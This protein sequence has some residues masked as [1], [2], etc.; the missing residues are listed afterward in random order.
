MNNRIKQNSC[1]AWLLAARPKTLSAASIPVVVASALAW[2]DGCFRM[3]PA[4]TCLLFAWLMQIAA[5]M[6]NDLFDFLKGS[7][8]S[9]RLGPERACAQGWISPKAMKKGIAVVLT[10]ACM[11]GLTLLCFGEP[12]LLI[13]IGVACVVFAF[14]YTTLLSYQGMGDILVLVFFGLV[15]VMGTYYVEAGSVSGDAVLASFICGILIDTL[16]VLNNYRD[17]DTDRRDGK[18]TL[19]VRFGE[20][21]GRYFYL[22]LGIVAWALCV[23]Y[24]IEGRTWAFVMPT[25]Y[26]FCHFSTWREMV[27]IREGKALNKI[28]GKTSFN[29]LLFSLLLATGLM[30]S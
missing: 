9:D 8:R 16:L 10:L 4:L 20:P 14:L 17:R 5:N 3:L 22:L 6:I 15:P 7:D 23:I 28:L 21:F 18:S 25:F 27:R 29:M 19:V 1:K 26:L 24:L 30:V 11:T 2:S 12:L 13:G